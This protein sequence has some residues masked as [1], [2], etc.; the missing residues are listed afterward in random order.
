[1]VCV[2]K[3]GG[4]R[5]GNFV[6][7]MECTVATEPSVLQ[8]G[9]PPVFTKRL[10]SMI[11]Q[12]V[13][14]EQFLGVKEGHPEGHHGILSFEDLWLQ[15]WTELSP[16][17]PNTI[18]NVLRVVGAEGACCSVNEICSFYVKAM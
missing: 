12:C 1:M 14:Q 8:L 6:L 13:K 5:S 3:D 11:S 2:I 9:T 17:V 16:P 18:F 4:W 10:Q 15:S 7:E